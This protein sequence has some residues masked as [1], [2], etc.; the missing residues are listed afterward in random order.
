[1][2][3]L[4]MKAARKAK[5]AKPVAKKRKVVRR[6]KAKKAAKK[7]KPARAKRR[8]ARRKKKA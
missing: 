2:S 7:A 6:K 1:M 4:I 3:T 5:K 8:V